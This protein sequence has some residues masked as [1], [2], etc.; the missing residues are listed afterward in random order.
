[1]KENKTVSKRRMR[2]E[3]LGKRAHQPYGS[4]HDVW[5]RIEIRSL[6]FVEVTAVLTF[7]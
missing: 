7:R 2:S 5:R 3:R 4:K 1:M 6:C